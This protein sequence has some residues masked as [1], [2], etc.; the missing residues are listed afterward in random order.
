MGSVQ[1]RRLATAQC[2][3]RVQA[4]VRAR[5]PA[6]DGYAAAFTNNARVIRPYDSVLSSSVSN[7]K[8]SILDNKSTAKFSAHDNARRLSG[9]Q[10]AWARSIALAVL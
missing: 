4:R 10:Q 1:P 5:R 3:L 8:A 2:D 6:F 7:N 9:A